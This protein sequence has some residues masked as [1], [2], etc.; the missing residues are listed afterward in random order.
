MDLNF[1]VLG[2]ALENL[3][4]RTLAGGGFRWPKRHFS[5]SDFYYSDTSNGNLKETPRSSEPDS[6]PSNWLHWRYS[7]FTLVYLRVEYGPVMFTASK[8]N[9]IAFLS[10][11]IS[12]CSCNLSPSLVD[13]SKQ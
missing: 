6:D 3:S 2:K 8:S 10:L 13:E 4:Q 7:L 11:D 5:A 12:S 9:F 1:T